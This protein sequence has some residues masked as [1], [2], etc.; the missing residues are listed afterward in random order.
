MTA[1]VTMEMPPINASIPWLRRTVQEMAEGTFHRDEGIRGIMASAMHPRGF[2]PRRTVMRIA[3]VLL[4][5][6]LFGCAVRREV[7]FTSTPTGAVIALHR[8]IFDM[9]GQALRTTP[10]QATIKESRRAVFITASIPGYETEV[11]VLPE[12]KRF[13]LHF[14]M[15]EGLE[16]RIQKEAESY[17]TAYTARAEEALL[18]CY[19]ILTAT[20]REARELA[21]DL[22]LASSEL[23]SLGTGKETGIELALALLT[24]GCERIARAGEE[25][26]WLASS[27]MTLEGWGLA[28]RAH[29]A[30]LFPN[31]DSPAP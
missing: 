26:S 4:A 3:G 9:E 1:V 13:D 10:C 7:R 22:R 31:A 30:L 15:S 23:R 21:R 27:R 29:V 19:E 18:R 14:V 12:Q 28:H 8:S 6:G 11:R 24:S 16:R 25:E 17:T 5:L 2:S 20:P